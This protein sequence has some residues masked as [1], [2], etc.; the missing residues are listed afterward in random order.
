MI[1]RNILSSESETKV[2]AS[3]FLGLLTRR[4]TAP[5]T[6]ALPREPKRRYFKEDYISILVCKNFST[7]IAIICIGS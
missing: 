5:R 1:I 3:E 6:Q 2:P 4:E 7:A